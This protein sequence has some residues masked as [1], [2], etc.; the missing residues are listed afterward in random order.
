[1]LEVYIKAGLDIPS[2]EVYEDFPQLE[3]GIG[4]LSKMKHEFDEKLSKTKSKELNR[5]I[6]IAVGKCAYKFILELSK[7]LE[8]HFKGLKI[9]VYPIE[10]T[11]FGEKITV[12]GLITGG[13]LINQ[14]ED[15]ELGD[16]LILTY[17]CL[18]DDED[19]FLDNI[20]LKEVKNALK[21]KIRVVKG[22]GGDFIKQIIK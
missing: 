8:N 21:V 17:S 15:K 9:N 11:F 18:K 1:M 12:S 10:N 7:K 19:I 13:D 3:D 4:M 5:T 22:T 20:T 6:S 14:L 2:Y 16:F